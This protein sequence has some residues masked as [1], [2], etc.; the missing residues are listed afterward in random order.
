MVFRRRIYRATDAG[1]Q[2]RTNPPAGLSLP[3]QRILALLEGDTHFEVIRKGMGFCDEKQI[4][5]WLI[6]LE[7]R[8]LV[9]WY[10]ERADSDLDFTDS[11]SL[12]ALAARHNAG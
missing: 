7:T 5:D 11:L 8:R 3:C 1:I 6:E 12:S 10:A 4:G 9:S 2:A